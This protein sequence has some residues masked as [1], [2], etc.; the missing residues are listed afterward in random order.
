[1]NTVA[2]HEG[3]DFSRRSFLA[4]LGVAAGSILAPMNGWRALTQDGSNSSLGER[5]ARLL[6]QGEGTYA[7]APHTWGQCQRRNLG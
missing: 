6:A 2:E 3:G 1:M 7:M 4:V 5:L